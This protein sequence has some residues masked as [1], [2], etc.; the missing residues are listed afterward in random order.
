[1][2]SLILWVVAALAFMF[3]GISMPGVVKR[4]KRA[5]ILA[6]WVQDFERLEGV[7][8]GMTASMREMAATWITLGAAFEAV[9]LVMEISEEEGNCECDYEEG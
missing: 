3:V 2:A 4:H 6:R 1:M 8:A 7:F 5:K 9:G